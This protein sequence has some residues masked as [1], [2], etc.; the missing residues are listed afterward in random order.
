MMKMLFTCHGKTLGLLAI[1]GIMGK[2]GHN[3]V[4]TRI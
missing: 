1:L 2:T 4:S 3:S